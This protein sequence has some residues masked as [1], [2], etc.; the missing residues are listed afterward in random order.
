MEDLICETEVID[1]EILLIM[2]YF[3]ERAPARNYSTCEDIQ[4]HE[5]VDVH[6]LPPD[7]GSRP[8]SKRRKVDL[9]SHANTRVFSFPLTSKS[10]KMQNAIFLAN[11]R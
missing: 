1:L 2:V 10:M 4:T 9:F 5:N 8:A 6:I 11:Q 3:L 7:Y